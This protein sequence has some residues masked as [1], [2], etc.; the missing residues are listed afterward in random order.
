MELTELKSA[1]NHASKIFE[2]LPDKIS[3]TEGAKSLRRTMEEENSLFAS[4]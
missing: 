1:R 3:V 2:W 4:S